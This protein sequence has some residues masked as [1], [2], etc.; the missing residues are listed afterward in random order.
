MAGVNVIRRDEFDEARD[1][2]L[3]DD[4]HGRRV[5]DYALAPRTSAPG[6]IATHNR[7]TGLEHQGSREQERRR[8][9]AARRAARS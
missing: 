5:P 8:R 4:R 7:H 1:I 6:S 3:V 2:T 9:Q